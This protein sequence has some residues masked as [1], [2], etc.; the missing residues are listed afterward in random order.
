[1]I[2]VLVADDHAVVRE[3]LK[4]ILARTDDLVV[5]GEAGRGEEVL[6]LAGKND[7]EVLLLDIT[8]PGRS[9]LDLVKQLKVL[10][11]DLQILM[12]S[13][14]SEE[15]Y[16]I[17]AL[18][19]GAAGYLVK[20]SAPEELIAAIRTVAGGRKYVSSSLAEILASRLETGTDRPLHESL[21]DREYDVLCKIAAGMT[22]KEIAADLCLSVKTISTYRTRL[23][24]KMHF[25]TNK[26]LT[27]Y[28]TQYGLID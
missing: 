28:A 8:M 4:K 11:P 15:Q 18:K 10:K 14:H 25:H 13:V 3:G 2:R 27:R 17:R 12:L 1:M 21:S 22:V 24:E 16:A 6:A 26:E 23:L 5:T 9:G 7:Y 19:A 20:E